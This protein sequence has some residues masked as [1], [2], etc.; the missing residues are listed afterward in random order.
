MPAPTITPLPTPPSR[1]TDP[2]NFAIEADAFV[3]A[4]PEFVTDA[5]AQASY[6]DGVATAVDADAVAAA[7]SA[8]AAEGFADDAEASA[9]GAAAAAD[10]SAWVSG[11]TYVIGDCVFSPIDFQTYRRTTNG[12]GTTDPSADAVNWLAI[13]SPGGSIFKAIASG[14]LS[15][16]STVA[17]NADGTVSV[18]SGVAQVVGT[19]SVFNSS[20]TNHISAT[21]DANSQRVIVAYQAVTGYGT[22]VVG[23][24]SGTSIT[25][26]T[27]VVFKSA[28][29]TVISAAYDP[30]TQKVVIAYTSTLG[31]AIVGTVSGTTISFGAE[32]T[33]ESAGVI[34]N[35]ITYDTNAQK[36]VLVYRNGS[37]FGAASVGTISGTSISFGSAVVFAAVGDTRVMSATYDTNAQR[38]V[39]A[40]QEYNN[41]SYGT[42]VVGTVSGT[43]ISFGTPVVFRSAAISL[44]SAT[45]DTNAQKVVIAYDASGAGNIIVGTVSGT[46]ITFGSAVV[47]AA[48][49]L[50]YVSAIY[51][52]NVRKI[53]IAYRASG[54]GFGN[55]IVG[56]VS[57]TSISFNT[58]VVFES[59]STN[60]IATA[61][62]TNTQKV[63]IAYQDTGNSSYGTAAVFQNEN[64]NF[65]S[66]IGFSSAAYT[67]GQT[68]T[69]QVVGSVDDA[70][71]A[72]VAGQSYY[73]QLNG[74]LGLTPATPSVFAGTAVSATKIIVKG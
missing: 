66:F 41:S 12:A 4:L 44:V 29:T 49:I 16:G 9:A 64:S 72:L 6:L 30:N 11:T 68:A 22:A 25:F 24:V 36:V 19:P 43:S 53:V 3:A 70:Q 55:V 71:S 10:V 54:A 74:T 59:A 7:A 40:Y 63:V 23:T 32:V 18:V 21:Y 57:G 15:N 35:T 51:D 27:P 60:W 56:T 50:T 65:R 8:T 20:T 17:V 39:I 73:V 1:S 46:T 2:T 42:A 31:R 47:F 13:T 38:V 45:Y 26:G 48:G 34:Y 67:D 28:T 14:V 37:N 62:D 52:P 61:Y 69:I 58:A 33:Y 5:N